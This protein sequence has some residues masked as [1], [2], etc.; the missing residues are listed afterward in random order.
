[1]PHAD[2]T[3]MSR[4]RPEA[5]PITQSN[6]PHFLCIGRLQVTSRQWTP[7]HLSNVTARTQAAQHKK[8]ST[9]HWMPSEHWARCCAIQCYRQ[10]TLHRNFWNTQLQYKV[11]DELKLVTKSQEK[12]SCCISSH[13]CL[14]CHTKVIGSC[15]KTHGWLDAAATANFQKPR[16]TIQPQSVVITDPTRQIPARNCKRPSLPAVKS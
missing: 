13:S 1:M 4:I 3:C 9:S 12:P 15:I 14:K 7:A 6:T 11:A 2:Q 16:T 8:A 10:L 5:H